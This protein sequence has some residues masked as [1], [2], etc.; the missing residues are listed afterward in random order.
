MRKHGNSFPKVVAAVYREHEWHPW[1]F[2]QVAVDFWTTENKRKFCDA[3]MKESNM[4][5]IFDWYRIKTI[6]LKRFGG[7]YLVGRVHTSLPDLLREV[8]PDHEWI[9]WKFANQAAGL[10][11]HKE[12]RIKFLDWFAKKHSFLGPEAWYN[13]T[14]TQLRREGGTYLLKRYNFVMHEMLE[15]AYK[16]H[17][18]L[19]WRFP[20]PPRLF[21][22][23]TKNQ[24][25][26]LH[27]FAES[28]NFASPEGWY[29][30]SR[31]DLIAVNGRGLVDEYG[32]SIPTMLRNMYPMHGWKDWLFGKTENNFWDSAANR[33]RYFDWAAD[34][35]KLESLEG[36][37]DIGTD[38]VYKQSGA[39]LLARHY[40]GSVMRAVMDI[41]PEHKWNVAKF[42]ATAALGR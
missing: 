33:R 23:D 31:A 9:D 17:K 41:Y 1:L 36:W 20:T 39:G 28:K 37:Y 25:E 5:S 6:Q 21:W 34:R 3:F 42:R 2:N 8:Y 7:G 24:K 32:G 38:D 22:K 27:W 35:L 4:T 14:P 13:V 19:P 15:D 11:A 18:W 26:F 29:G 10:W 30:V 40:G 12:N 16:P